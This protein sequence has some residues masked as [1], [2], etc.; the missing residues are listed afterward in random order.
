ML[1]QQLK[2]FLV[3]VFFICKYI[4]EK[5]RAWATGTVNAPSA[6]IAPIAIYME[7]VAV[8]NRAYRAVYV[9]RDEGEVELVEVIEVNKHEYKK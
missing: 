9:E 2:Q 7:C 3:K 8:P 1:R 5:F 6:S 4:A